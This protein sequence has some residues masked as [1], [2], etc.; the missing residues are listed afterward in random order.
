MLRCLPKHSALVINM[1]LSPVVVRVRAAWK[2]R[3]Y[4]RLTRPAGLYVPP[5]LLDEAPPVPDLPALA[6]S[7]DAEWLTRAGGER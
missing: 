4:R 6:D 2:R 3:D 1:N 5:Q 7:A